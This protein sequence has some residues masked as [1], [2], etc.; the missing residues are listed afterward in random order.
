MTAEQTPLP[1]KPR[2]WLV[3][4]V[5]LMVIL[6]TIL[7]LAVGGT[8]LAANTTWGRSQIAAAI[9][10]LDSVSVGEIEGSLFS[11]ITVSDIELA[12]AQGTWVSIPQARL[13]W[14]P[15]PFVGRTV[16]VK[17]IQV[18]KV[19]VLRAPIASESQEEPTAP[20]ELTDITD[21]PVSILLSN[22]EIGEVIWTGEDGAQGSVTIAATGRL[23]RGEDV[24]LALAIVPITEGFDDEVNA[25]VVLNTLTDTASTKLT[26]KASA[27][28]LLASLLGLPGETNAALEGG[29]TPSEWSGTLRADVGGQSIA[30]LNAQFATPEGSAQGS[31]FILPFLDP[32]ATDIANSAF[33]V[34]TRFEKAGAQAIMLAG[35]IANNALMATISGTVSAPDRQPTAKDL[36][37]ETA[38]TGTAADVRLDGINTQLT[39]NGRLEALSAT[40]RLNARTIETPAATLNALVINGSAKRGNNT[41]TAAAQGGI[42][43]VSGVEGVDP[44]ILKALQFSMDVEAAKAITAV[45][46]ANNGFFDVEAKTLEQTPGGAL[47]ADITFSVPD[48]QKFP[49]AF[50]A[51][52]SG[53]ATL[54][55]SETGTT[56][57]A[58]SSALTPEPGTQ[59]WIGRLAQTPL[60]IKAR[61]A[62]SNG[63]VNVPRFS[64]KSDRTDISGRAALNGEKIEANIK[65]SI[66]GAA[67]ADIAKGA[68]D[69]AARFDLSAQGPISTV[70]PR[71]TLTLPGLAAADIIMRDLQIDF[72]PQGT[73]TAILLNGSSN[74]GPIKAKVLVERFENGMISIDDMTAR[75]A[76]IN[77]QGS[78]SA[79]AA[80]GPVADVKLAILPLALAESGLL[81][82]SGEMEI[83]AQLSNGPA[84]ALILS[85]GGPIL[86][87]GPAGAPTAQLRN[88]NLDGQIDLTVDTPQ[89]TATLNAEA[90]E[91]AGFYFDSLT[92]TAEQEGTAQ[93]AKATLM[94][95]GPRPTNATFLMDV[96]SEGANTILDITPSG[97]LAGAPLASNNPI[98]ITA[99]DEAL[100]VAPARL[101]IG[102]GSLTLQATQTD[103][104][105]TASADIKNFQLRAITDLLQQPAYMGTLSSDLEFSAQRGEGSLAA[106]FEVKNLTADAANKANL[107]ISG[108]ALADSAKFS[109]T[110]IAGQNT[111][112]QDLK[113]QASVPVSWP[114]SPS[115]FEIAADAPLDGA[116]A[117]DTRLAPWWQLA[118]LVDQTLSGALA[119]NIALGGTLEAPTTQGQITLSDARYEHLE[120]GTQINDLNA[121]IAL[122]DKQVA[123]ES[124]S[125]NDGRGGTVSASAVVDLFPALPQRSQIIMKD[126][127]LLA[128]DGLLAR[129]DADLAL[130]AVDGRLGLKGDITIAEARYAIA[131]DGAAAVQTLPVE[132]I[133][134]GALD[135]QQ[136]GASV[137]VNAAA[138]T[139]ETGLPP[140]DL[141]MKVKAERRIFVTGMGLS[142]EWKTDLDITGTADKPSI[143][144]SVQLVRGELQFAG[145]RFQLERGQIFLDGGDQIEPRLDILAQNVQGDFTA[146]IGITGT[147]SDPQ[148]TLSSTPALPDDEILSRILFGTSASDLS[149]LEA[150]QLGSAVAALSSGGGSSALDIA[151]KARSATGLDRLYLGSNDSSTAIT[152]GKYL[153][154]DVFLQ[155]TTDPGTGQFLAAIEWYLT[156]SLSVLSEYGAQTGS[157]VAARWSRTY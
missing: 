100:L 110:I 35:T 9:S 134:V 70:M 20:F 8:L 60:S 151:G 66:A 95:S 77:V 6:V 111:A 90:L 122:Q 149:A 28:G 157:N 41:V 59:H 152:G 145:K 80:D 55:Q 85:G 138:D 130:S 26:L 115:F 45:A 7:I 3:A 17:D 49:S 92:L 116:I 107:T 113:A 5:W 72:A 38:L 119:G 81:G 128:K 31:F 139:V 141:G 108:T 153:S 36:V 146:R 150:V 96:Q 32:A 13:S 127:Q 112:G 57:I 155:F 61:A 129:T 12:D 16:K 14:S 1:P 132:E 73:Q 102:G 123:L 88:L 63:T 39:L 24:E 104:A 50:E 137:D 58:L 64:L 22:L 37:I 15:W 103:A 33:T 11:S 21:Q 47:A 144:G 71:G 76:N 34:D 143:A 131:A 91:A 84:R 142:S 140:I 53:K 68:G 117:L 69:A 147:P 48:L 105:L 86:T 82:L 98:R 18:P 106:A 156:R 97:Q 94:Q 89:I 2:S 121:Q 136:A 54:N 40:L 87:Y 46:Q 4:T 10:D 29:G 27:G 42:Q 51:A 30:D 79:G 75:L 148:I 52:L 62:L 118:D 67:F 44:D 93:S 135:G 125:A 56:T 74:A 124:L 114:Q 19:T 133:N 154:E 99:S 23:Q 83:S 65:G 101:T 43:S 78:A 120:F 109:A 126:F 25:D